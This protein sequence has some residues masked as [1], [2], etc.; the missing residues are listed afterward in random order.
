MVGLEEGG[1]AKRS[2]RV[3]DTFLLP[4]P[5]LLIGKTNASRSQ[6]GGTEDVLVGAVRY[7]SV[8]QNAQHK[9][10]GNHQESGKHCG[11]GLGHH[12]A[13]EPH[14]RVL[15]VL[16]E[17]RAPQNGIALV[18]HVSD[19]DS[20]SARPLARGDGGGGWAA[21]ECVWVGWQLSMLQWDA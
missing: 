11:A 1:G 10:K 5:L 14:R 18:C 8:V 13:G 17:A 4:L 3:G 21:W 12:N 19:Q 15:R 7:M 9:K 6:I 2:T 20:R 16:W